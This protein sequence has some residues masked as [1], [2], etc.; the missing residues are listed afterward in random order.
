MAR[1]TFFSFHYRNDVNR[2]MVVR[3]SWVTMADREAAGFTDAAAFEEI[4][5]KGQAAVEA[6]IDEQLKGT[7]VTVVLI[8]SETSTRPY[9]KTELKKSYAKGNGMLGIYIHQIKDM[10]TG[11]TSTKG[12]NQFGQIGTDSNGNAVY[13]SNSY[14]CYDWID[15][16][17]YENIG[18]WIKAAAE[19]A[20]K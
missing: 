6:W 2:A 20:G 10:N 19:K 13:F 7:S 4:K 11:T 18:A 8:G 1:R 12:S 16:K 15:D 5:K 9:C 14:P 17:G 3:N